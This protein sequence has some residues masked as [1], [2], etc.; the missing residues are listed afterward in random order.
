M[1]GE[2]ALLKSGIFFAKLMIKT[3]ATLFKRVIDGTMDE[4]DFSDNEDDNEE[5]EDGE[6]EFE[7]EYS[8]EAKRRDVVD[9]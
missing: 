8:H 1:A 4:L 9:I 5:D 3:G 7:E 2:R 6:E